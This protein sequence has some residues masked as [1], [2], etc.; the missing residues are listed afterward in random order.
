VLFVGL[1]FNSLL[2]WSWA[3][4]IAAWVIAGIAVKGGLNDW[5][6]DSCCGPN[7]SLPSAHEHSCGS[8]GSCCQTRR[9]R[10]RN[11]AASEGRCG[12]PEMLSIAPPA[13]ADFL[14]ATPRSTM[15]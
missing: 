10:S 5:R 1:G 14:P 11:A 7:A 8:G 4:P 9:A 6:D 13:P 12:T 15:A 3:D 2:G